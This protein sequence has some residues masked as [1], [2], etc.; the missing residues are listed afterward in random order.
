MPAML[1]RDVRVIRQ[2]C[3]CYFM[4][5]YPIGEFVSGVG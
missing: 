4:E 1:T 3:L 2:D 5:R